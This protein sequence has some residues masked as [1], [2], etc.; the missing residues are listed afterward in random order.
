MKIDW[1]TMDY[2]RLY[3]NR[4]VWATPFT[5]CANGKI[6]INPSE[7]NLSQEKALSECELLTTYRE[8]RRIIHILAAR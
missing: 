5:D 1:K 6:S 3:F 2:V 8:N 4:F 7:A